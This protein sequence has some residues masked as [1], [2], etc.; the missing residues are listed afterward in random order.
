MPDNPA[1]KEVADFHARH[2]TALKNVI[3]GQTEAIDHIMVA[4]VSGGH[5]LL[6][7]PAATAKGLLVQCLARTSQ[8][9][10]RSIQLTPDLMPSDI[11]GTEILEEDTGGERA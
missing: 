4:L 6:T 3:V 1:L 9:D 11:T 10:F 7:G 5:V 2:S 8:L